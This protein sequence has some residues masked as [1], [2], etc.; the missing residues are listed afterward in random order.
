MQFDE[1]KHP[2]NKGG[3]FAKLGVTDELWNV[4]VKEFYE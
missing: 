2:R 3:E 1:S 4:N